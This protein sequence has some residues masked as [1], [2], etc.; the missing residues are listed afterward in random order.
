VIFIF[1][2]ILILML[3]ASSSLQSPSYRAR[4]FALRSLLMTLFFFFFLVLLSSKSFLLGHFLGS[5]SVGYQNIFF[6]LDSFPTTSWP[7]LRAALP[8]FDPGTSEG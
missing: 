6:S 7:P 4:A 8:F 2:L 1:F 3:G 5:S